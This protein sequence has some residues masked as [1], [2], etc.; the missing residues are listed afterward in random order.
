MDVS[1]E[2]YRGVLDPSV[3]YVIRELG[4]TNLDIIQL[5]IIT[6]FEF[7]NKARIVSVMKIYL[8][9]DLACSWI[10]NR[11]EIAAIPK[12]ASLWIRDETLIPSNVDLIVF[13]AV[14]EVRDLV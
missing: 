2:Q 7:R 4:D 10:R 6:S 9:H 13:L 3:W 5:E 11:V 1:R 8:A 12:S 14:D